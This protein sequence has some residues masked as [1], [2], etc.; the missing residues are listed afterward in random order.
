M[1]R[2]ESGNVIFLILIAI[3]LFAALSI[4]VTNST[5]S[6]G[7]NTDRERITLDATDYVRIGTQINTTVQ[8]LLLTG[9]CT[10][11]QIS[12]DTTPGT[13][14]EDNPNAPTDLSCHVFVPGAGFVPVPADLHT[15]ATVPGWIETSNIRLETIGAS[16]VGGAG[17]P[18]CEL[19]WVHYHMDPAICQEINKNLLGDKT[20]HTHNTALGA[21]TTYD[22]TFTDTYFVTSTS[23]GGS[24]AYENQDSF[25]IEEGGGQNSH[26]YVQ[27]IAAR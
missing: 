7:G 3:A 24:T 10:L 11:E 27:V 5:R 17:C 8:T 16:D 26:V 20:V 25:C 23:I 22:G 2:S 14:G 21:P 6:G 1:R 15:S 12:F 13:G 4:A 9:G 19:L 18:G